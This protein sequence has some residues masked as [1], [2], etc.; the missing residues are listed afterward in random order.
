[1]NFS[2]FKLHPQIIAGIKAQGYVLP[3]Q[4]QKQAIPQ[5][6]EGHDVMGFA[7]TG[8]GKTTAFVLPI[9]ERLSPGPADPCGRSSLRRHESSP[10]RSMHP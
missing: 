5:V 4:S 9:L 3:T 8:T 7:Q 6:L 1:M 10:N 2:S